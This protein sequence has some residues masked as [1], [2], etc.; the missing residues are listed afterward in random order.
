MSKK[1][2][3]ELEELSPLLRQL[4]EQGDGLETP[5]D[6]FDSFE[7]NL[8]L[9]M[10]KQGV[11]RHALQQVH[12]PVQRRMWPGVLAA[13]ASLALI[14]GAVWYFN[15]G[16]DPR[17]LVAMELSPEEI[18]AYMMENAA[19][20]E[21][22]QLAALEEVP[23]ENNQPVTPDKTT[24]TPENEA[25]PPGGLEEIIDEMTDEELAELL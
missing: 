12:I 19:D 7:D 16:S 20:F 2:N 18:T 10:A 11:R 1:I 21:P 9:R 13:A 6:Y 8:K 17:E 15:T 23:A 25:V 14:L 24:T 3:Q 5:H 4:R 22:E